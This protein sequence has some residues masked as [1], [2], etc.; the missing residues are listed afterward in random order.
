MRILKLDTE[1]TADKPSPILDARN[2][3]WWRAKRR[4]SKVLKN[5]KPKEILVLANDEGV[6]DK[7]KTLAGEFGY[8]W[9]VNERQTWFDIT[10][11]CE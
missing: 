11:T 1:I 6:R 8:R 3:G 4:V 10:L 2:L 9:E 7:I 5:E